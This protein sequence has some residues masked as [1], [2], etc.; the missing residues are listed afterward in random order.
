MAYL[1]THLKGM[2]MHVRPGFSNENESIQ[3]VDQSAAQLT[4]TDAQRKL[5]EEVMSV[6]PALNWDRGAIR[7]TDEE[8]IPLLE[9]AKKLLTELMNP[10]LG[11]H[12]SIS[13]KYYAAILAK[14]LGIYYGYHQR[15]FDLAI[16]YLTT[17]KQLAIPGSLDQVHA[18]M[19]LGYT[20]TIRPGY[21]DRTLF[22][23]ALADLATWEE[24][25]LTAGNLDPEK[26]LEISV[27]RGYIECFLGLVIHRKSYQTTGISEQ[28]RVAF[29]EDAIV[30]LKQGQVYQEAALATAASSAELSNLHTQI[31][32]EL[33]NT[34]HIESICH[35]KIPRR[36]EELAALDKAI[37]LENKYKV[38]TGRDHFLLY[39]SLQN[40]SRTNGL[41]LGKLE[42]AVKTLQ[43][44]VL[45]GQQR[46]YR[47]KVTRVNT[48]NLDIAK[49]YHFAGE[50]LLKLKENREALQTFLLALEMKLRLKSSVL[51]FDVMDTQTQLLTAANNLVSLENATDLPLLVK[52]MD[53]VIKLDWNNH[54]IIAGFEK[55][56]KPV[57]QLVD[58]LR[59]HLPE[60]HRE[61]MKLLLAKMYE[62]GAFHNHLKRSQPHVA[63]TYL[64]PALAYLETRPVVDPE[65]HYWMIDHLAFTYHQ[66]LA[67][68]FNKD[69]DYLRSRYALYE[70]EGADQLSA[71]EIR[72][73]FYAKSM[74]AADKPMRF[75]S[76]DPV[77]QNRIRA[78]AHLISSYNK[79]ER[80]RSMTDQ[81][82]RIAELF[83]VV[84]EC[85]E[86]VQGYYDQNDYQ[87]QVLRASN[88]LA[89]ITSALVVLLNL[90]NRQDEIAQLPNPLAIYEAN[91]AK[92]KE[93]KTEAGNPFAGRG[94]FSEAIYLST[95][96]FKANDLSA[97]N[98]EILRKAIEA[99][100]S[101][102]AILAVSEGAKDGFTLDALKAKIEMQ[103]KLIAIID[104]LDPQEQADLIAT[105]P[106][107]DAIVAEIKKSLTAHELEKTD[108]GIKVDSAIDARRAKLA[109]KLSTG[110]TATQA[111][112]F[113]GS[114][115]AATEASAKA[116]AELAALQQQ[117][118]R[119]VSLTGG[120]QPQ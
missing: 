119:S 56:L 111:G 2:V 7:V 69:I 25:R 10:D 40:Y 72:N 18:N 87:E 32:I 103:L 47:D 71:E 27:D 59:P 34:Y 100:A 54:Q 83:E 112:L 33:P 57:T 101:A 66:E 63:F 39:V 76:A 93:L 35:S 116:A 36:T 41:Y 52:A 65:L 38:K 74:E 50:I 92:R 108:F 107:V 106:Q 86:A 61:L 15:D 44:I 45:P 67:Q 6:V 90:A 5:R 31:L 28:E 84:A 114:E 105:L 48:D 70:K 97:E 117:Q 79:F 53:A 46:L 82:Q 60:H 85:R 64:Q 77:I 20:S 58:Y 78:F 3:V 26:I 1:K 113:S 22:D 88:R 89:D 29:L 23:Q 37:E 73:Y 24:R 21:N 12:P 102:H 19:Y 81:A 62:L 94:Y 14:Q 68:S 11:D 4:E 30:H 80:Q 75:T 8:L 96:L 98:I 49:T 118:A 17:Y 109:A 95:K 115:R 43:T 16:E 91:K 55:L 13:P 99:Y 9:K 110:S 120:S 51:A 104:A 42:E